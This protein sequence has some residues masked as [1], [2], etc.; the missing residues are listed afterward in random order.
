M[1]KRILCIGDNHLPYV[2]KEVFHK[3]VKEV[4]PSFK[5]HIIVDQG[6]KFDLYSFSRFPAKVI[7]PKREFE[8]AIIL[9]EDM[10]KQIRKAA[11]KAK[12]Y[13]LKGNHDS[14]AYLRMMEK[15]PHLESL[16]NFQSPWE[17]KGVET[18]H[19]VTEPLII[20]DI[21]FMHGHKTKIGAHLVD[22]QYAK[23]IVIGHLHTA[24]IHI[25]RVGMKDGLVRWEACAGYIA[26]PYHFALSYRPLKKFFKWTHGVLLIEN[27]VPRF[28]PL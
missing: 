11:P 4:I 20:D 12:C 14:R 18:I 17:F 23:N 9:A 13:Q 1:S 24:G 21:M 2:N 6:D 27:N 8:E 3:I 19:D 10:W 5:P 28:L 25:E 26:D 15:A 16:I 22:I 7:D